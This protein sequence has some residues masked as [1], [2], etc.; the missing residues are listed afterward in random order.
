MQPLRF[1]STPMP[2]DIFNESSQR[3]ILAAAEGILKRKLKRQGSIGDP[4][5]VADY[6]R[7]RLTGAGIGT[8]IAKAMG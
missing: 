6:P 3:A 2:I 7:A 4:A 5:D 8:G 1:S